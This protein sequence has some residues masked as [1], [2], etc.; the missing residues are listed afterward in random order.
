MG[1]Q[2]EMTDYLEETEERLNGIEDDLEE[3][4]TSLET[5]KNPFSEE[6]EIGNA[7]YQW[8]P[9]T[10]NSPAQSRARDKYEDWYNGVEIIVYQYMPRRYEDFQDGHTKIIDYLTLDTGW[11]ETPPEDPIEWKVK[12]MEILNGQRSIAKSAPSRVA[13]EQF[14]ARKEISAQVEDDEITRARRLFEDGL[15]REGGVIAG[16]ALERRL[17]TMCETSER[18]IDYNPSH[19]IDRL[20]QT[21][22]DDANEIRTQDMKHLQYL[23]SIRGKCAHPGEEPDEQEVERL[24]THTEEYLR[25]GFEK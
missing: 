20:S 24:L 7:S 3:Y 5:K 12:V 2:E 19:S 1:F 18:D 11:L 15:I 10:E 6:I 9:R 22:H 21:L 16:V 17:L 4:F 8:V 25:E 23:G 14:K 13:A